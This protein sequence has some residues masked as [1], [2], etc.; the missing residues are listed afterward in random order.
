L[1]DLILEHGGGV[2]AAAQEF[3]IAPEQWLDLSTGINPLGW[4][5]PSLP[6]E[7]WQRL[8]QVED[9]LQE[10][11]RHYYGAKQLLPVAGSQAAIMALPR[12]RPQSRVGLM[13]P[14]YAEHAHAWRS[15]GHELIE[16]HRAADIEARLDQ[17]DVLLLIHPNNPTG[18]TFTPQQLLQWHERLAVHDGWLVVDE[19]FV[20]ATPELSI[21][22]A[23]GLPG[24]IVLRSLG[25]FF[26]LAG[27]RVG[28][29]LAWPE[30]L[31]RL[32]ELLGPWGISGPG[33]EVA[34]LALLDTPWQRAT[35]Q[36]LEADGERLA[37]ML[38]ENGLTSTG[39]VL[40]RYCHTDDAG[41]LWR[42]MAQRGILL[43]RFSDPAALRF[44]LPGDASQWQRLEQ[45]LVET[46]IAPEVSRCHA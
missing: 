23:C 14:G 43:R 41:D 10:A 21:A 34:R 20:D 46:V 31:Q 25:K 19:A 44:G 18:Q 29:L 27:A 2:L 42:A 45:A 33:R 26:G 3:G 8:P 35:R 30:L 11:A 15:E 13:V 7:C 40:F 24:L 22:A 38:E 4:P 17:L 32:S 37:G 1:A 12:L 5:V 16:L 36:R 6:A 9:G 28:F 39:T